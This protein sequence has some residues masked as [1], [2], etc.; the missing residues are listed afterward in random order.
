MIRRSVPAISTMTSIN[1]AFLR[2]A[3]T[4]AN[5]SA[6]IVVLGTLV[7]FFFRCG[8]I[9]VSSGVAFASS[10]CYESSPLRRSAPM[11]MLSH[12]YPAPDTGSGPSWLT[13][14]GQMQLDQYNQTAPKKLRQYSYSD[15]GSNL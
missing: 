10:N 7:D 12:Y 1:S 9:R 13:F 2:L 3:N 11:S 4:R 6:D 8:M 14:I 5:R 15:K